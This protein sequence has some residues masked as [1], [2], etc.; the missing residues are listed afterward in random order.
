[1]VKPN[2]PPRH[3]NRN[4]IGAAIAIQIKPSMAK[5]ISPR[6]NI[7]REVQLILIASVFV[8]FLL[9]PN[10]TVDD[11]PIKSGVRMN[12]AIPYCPIL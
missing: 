8:R 6:V 2:S 11:K 7:P 4:P 9:C 5:Q 12:K 1:M 3:A 10:N